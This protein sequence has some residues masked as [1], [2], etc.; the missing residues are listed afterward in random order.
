MLVEGHTDS[1]GGAAYNLSLS[2]HRAESVVAD[3]THR[4][5]VAAA[6][7]RAVGYGETRPVATNATAAGKALNRRVELVRF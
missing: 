4:Y 1:D 6:R 7:L 5:R 3:L 2:Q